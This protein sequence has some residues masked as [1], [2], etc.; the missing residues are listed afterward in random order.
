M[1]G[2]LGDT[3]YS[4]LGSVPKDSLK[5]V[6]LTPNSLLYSLLSCPFLK[7][8]LAKTITILGE[9]IK[10]LWYIT[11]GYAPSNTLKQLSVNINSLSS[12]IFQ[13]L[14]NVPKQFIK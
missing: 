14:I 4:T 9:T 8:I 5:K 7:I 2:I 3:K 1:F 11:I 10:K 12:S 6:G 13:I